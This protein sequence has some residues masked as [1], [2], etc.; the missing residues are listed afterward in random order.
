MN[1]ENLRLAYI[2]RADQL[3]Q[4]EKD[5]AFAVEDRA[6]RDREAAYQKLQDKRAAMR[7]RLQDDA[8]Y[9]SN[10]ISMINASRGQ[11]R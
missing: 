5:N 3:R 8:A 4:A 11:G 9:K 7:Q 1:K 10:L 6:Y 2:T